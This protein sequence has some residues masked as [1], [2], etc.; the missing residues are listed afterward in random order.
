MLARDDK[1]GT[2]PPRSSILGALGGLLVAENQGDIVDEVFFICDA[3]GIERP[4]RNDEL[5]CYEFEWERE[6]DN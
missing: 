6:R 5:E 3:L 4:V 1:F 2:K